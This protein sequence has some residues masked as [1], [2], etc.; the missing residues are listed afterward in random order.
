MNTKQIGAFGEQA[1]AEYLEDM[2][3]EILERNYLMKFGEI[4]II[5]R[6]GSCIVFVE[7]KTRRNNLFGEPS[8]YVNYKKQRAVKLVAAA[9]TDVVNNE[10]RFDVIEVFYSERGG[11]LEVNNINHIENAF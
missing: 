10:I 8:E 6:Q 7:V 2:D 4:D 9:Y 1:A 11:R 5:A 3:Y